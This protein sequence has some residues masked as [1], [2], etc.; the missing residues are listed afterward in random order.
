MGFRLN[1]GASF[2][3]VYRSSSLLLESFTSLREKRANLGLHYYLVVFE[4][5]GLC[6]HFIRFFALFL[7]FKSL[8]MRNF[9]RI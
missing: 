9:E 8:G 2:I 4:N 5:V 6:V 1:N 7:N 3:D